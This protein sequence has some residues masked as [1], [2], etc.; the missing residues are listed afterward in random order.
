M[1]RIPGFDC[2]AVSLPARGVGG[3]FYDGFALG[4]GLW[5]LLLGD[6]SGKGVAAGLVATSVQARVQTA[7]RHARLGP[8]D[9]AD[10]LNLDVFASTQGQRYATLVYG[11]LDAEARELS[12]VNAGHPAALLFEAGAACPIEVA[13]TGPALGLM[14]TAR[15]DARS[16]HLPPGSTFVVFT[17]G[18]VEALD[19]R[20]VEFG[21]TRTVAL[22]RSVRHEAA[23]A[24]C[25]ALVKAVGHHRGRR[26]H[27]DDVTVMVVRSC[28]HSS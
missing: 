5:G 16:V 12:M 28:E 10:A 9:L 26:Q 17:D 13:A 24:Q 22:L 14:D 23:A 27:Q 6:V 21:D 20:D 2:A 4:S 1:P 19:D 25:T 7:A 18:V 15:F 8:A 3:D 11:T